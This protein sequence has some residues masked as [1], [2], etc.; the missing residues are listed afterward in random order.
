MKAYEC[1]AREFGL[2]FFT[3]MFM[4]FTRDIEGVK[5]EDGHRHFVFIWK[6]FLRVK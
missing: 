2:Y 4:F 5:A 3:V 1:W 6:K